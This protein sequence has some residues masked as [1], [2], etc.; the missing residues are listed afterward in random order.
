MS[1]SSPQFDEI[2]YWSEVKLE[3]IK[4]YAKAYSMILAAQRRPAFEHVYIDGFAGWGVH[5]SRETGEFV[6]GSPSNALLV[7]PPFLDKRKV[8]AL[9]RIADQRQDVHVFEGDC[10]RI[11]LENVFPRVRYEDYR[12]ALCLLDPY[13]LDLK[14]QVIKA[15]GKMQSIDMF[16]NFPVMD[17][18]RNALWRNPAAVSKTGIAKMKAFWGDDSWRSVVYKPVPTLFGLEEEK[19]GNAVVAEAFRKRLKQVA[20][21]KEV[22]Q[23]MPMRNSRGATVYYLLLASQKLVAKDII[24]DIFRK[25]A[26]HGGA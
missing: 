11:L 8:R 1:R 24:E 19:L 10:N 9:R 26:E 18:N 22:A 7:E 25:Y 17:M 2:G 14:W 4:E 23:P 20:G 6:P 15:A 3:I 5:V 16:L 12:R 21:F 13:G